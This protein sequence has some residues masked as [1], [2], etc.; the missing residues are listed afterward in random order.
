[1]IS[2]TRTAIVFLVLLFAA[3]ATAD[4]QAAAKRTRDRNTLTTEEIESSTA[5]SVYQLIQQKRPRWLS[6]RGSST[7]R[8]QTGTDA[9]GRSYEAPAD[10]EIAVY[11]DDVKHGAQDV[12][13]TM[14]PHQ[15]E[16]ME[17]LDAASA[18][19]RFGT[20]H[21]YGAILVRRKGR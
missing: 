7:L 16:F 2:L 18:T 6:P 19:Q 20:N 17:Y 4:A 3:Q 10:P 21:E 13:R 8:T 1:M 9:L 5:A 11:V 12:L 15:V 14:P